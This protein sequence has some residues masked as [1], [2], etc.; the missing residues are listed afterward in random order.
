MTGER[1]L[2]ADA[3]QAF[4]V[5][6]EHLS[7]TTA[8]TAL[9]I[10]QPSLHVKIKK[11]GSSLGVVLYER[12]GR[13]LRLTEDGRRLAAFA[14][15]SRRR[16][17]DFLAELRA[18]RAP[19]T[20]AAG[21]GTVRWVVADALRSLARAGRE[22]RVVTAG[23]DDALAALTTGRADLAV[24]AFDPPPAAL[25]ATEIAV[26]AQVLMIDARHPLATH[27]RLRLRDLDDLELVAPPAGR[28]HRRALDRARIDAGVDWRITAEVDGWDL[29]VHLALLG[30]GGT[31]VN[32]C[33]EVP[34]GL[35]AVPVIDLPAVRYWAVWREQRRAHIADVVGLLVAGA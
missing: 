3:L 34:D 12:D 5:F 23:R 10:S 20:I 4:S 1:I 35:V 25:P 6:A 29:L 30:F 28:A 21:R 14:A 31:I 2:T 24:V 13:G 33:V 16:L 26:H 11:L 19:V 27:D 17:D 18:G 9:H 8:S 32:G 7:F 15:D 22:V